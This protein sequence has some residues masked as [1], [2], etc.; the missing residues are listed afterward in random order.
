MILGW[1]KFCCLMLL[2]IKSSSSV[3]FSVKGAMGVTLIKKVKTS[4]KPLITVHPSL[5]FHLTS[6][7][8]YFVHLNCIVIRLRPWENSVLWVSLTFNNLKPHLSQVSISLNKIRVGHGLKIVQITLILM[9]IV[10]FCSNQT[11]SARVFLTDDFINIY[12]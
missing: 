7:S 5:N 10:N 11:T 8:I 4:L 6:G 12:N 1:L 3:V 2:M 9:A